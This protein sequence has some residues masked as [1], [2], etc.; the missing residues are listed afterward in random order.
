MVVCCAKCLWLIS[1]MFRTCIPTFLD[2]QFLCRYVMDRVPCF[3]VNTFSGYLRPSLKTMFVQKCHPNKKSD[4]VSS[5]KK[6]H[7]SCRVFEAKQNDWQ[8]RCDWGATSNSVLIGNG[9]QP[10]QFLALGLQEKPEQLKNLSAQGTRVRNPMGRASK[11]SSKAT[12][13]DARWS[14]ERP[15]SFQVTLTSRMLVAFWEPERSQLKAGYG[16]YDCGE[17]N[18]RLKGPCALRKG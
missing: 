4:R 15:R 11:S 8:G 14:Q 16:T 2:H 6:Q 18:A 17:L 3:V 1:I 12:K 5:S 9:W 13:R 7:S 10:N